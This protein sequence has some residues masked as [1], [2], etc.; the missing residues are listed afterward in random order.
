M[1]LLLAAAQVSPSNI[2]ADA[3]FLAL[4][5]GNCEDADHRSMPNWFSLQLTCVD[6]SS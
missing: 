4:G 3:D 6:D 1:D 2:T 5:V